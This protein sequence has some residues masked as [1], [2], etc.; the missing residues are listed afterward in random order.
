MQSFL[1]FILHLKHFR[2]FGQ[3][4]NSLLNLNDRNNGVM[5]PYSFSDNGK[6]PFSKL[7]V[8]EWYTIWNVLMS[9]THTSY[10]HKWSSLYLWE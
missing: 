10:Q 7:G 5:W 2:V 6:C 1:L 3:K 9:I 4:S 8:H